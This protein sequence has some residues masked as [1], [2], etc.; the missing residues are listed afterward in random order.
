MAFRQIPTARQLLS[1]KT[2]AL[3]ALVL[4]FFILT[5]VFQ[6]TRYERY[7]QIFG[8]L[9]LID[10]AATALVTNLRRTARQ[11]GSIWSYIRI[12]AGPTLMIAA[13]VWTS[14]TGQM[15]SVSMLGFMVLWAAAVVFMGYEIFISLRS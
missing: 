1:W 3:A 4:V 9:L 7:L 10:I 2:W 14:L 11:H 15:W 5:F 13:I 12:L 8:L 6:A